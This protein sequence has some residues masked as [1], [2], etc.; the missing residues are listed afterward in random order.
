[1]YVNFLGYLNI[2][3]II[4]PVALGPGVYSAS[5]RNEYQK[6]KNNVSG[7]QSSGRCVEPT[8][9]PP[10]VS[11]LFRQCGILNILQPY[12]PPRP[13]MN[14]FTLLLFYSSPVVPHIFTVD[15]ADYLGVY[16]NYYHFNDL[17]YI[18]GRRL[19]GFCGTANK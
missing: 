10:S 19:Y 12:R 1:M 8:T 15:D 17:F 6:H 7:E 14:S 5:G 16:V 3:G 4:L 11:R 18:Q 2:Y 9:L 13:V